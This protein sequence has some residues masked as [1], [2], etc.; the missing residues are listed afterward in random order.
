MVTYPLASL[1]QVIETTMLTA[2]FASMGR[3]VFALPL[4]EGSPAAPSVRCRA[5]QQK[6]PRCRIVL[7]Q[8]RRVSGITGR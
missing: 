4:Y 6:A 2:F 8:M 7:F 3:S 1:L 5:N